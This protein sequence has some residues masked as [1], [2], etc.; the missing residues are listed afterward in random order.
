MIMP[1]EEIPASTTSQNYLI[2]HVKIRI[3]KYW[4]GL[5]TPSSLIILHKE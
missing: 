3:N 2:P 5:M 4:K 1:S